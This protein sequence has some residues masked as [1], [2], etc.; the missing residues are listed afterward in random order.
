MLAGR[1]T[2]IVLLSILSV[3]LVRTSARLPIGQFF[4]ISSL[5]VAALA[6]ILTGKG[7]ASLQEAGSHDALFKVIEH[8]AEKAKSSR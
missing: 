7:I 2:G 3:V 6:I 8:L 4:A 5:M 1:G